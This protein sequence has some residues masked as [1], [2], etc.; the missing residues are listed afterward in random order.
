M[1]DHTFRTPVPLPSERLV[2]E[3]QTHCLFVG[4]CFSDEVGQRASAAGV[5]AVSNPAGALYNMES[6]RL[7]LQRW[8][9]GR[10]TTGNDVFE[11]ADGLWHSRQHS[12]A[13]D[14]RDKA[15]CLMRCRQSDEVGIAAFRKADI[16][17]A[18]AGTNRLYRH[19][20]SS[21]VVANCHKQ[22][23]SEYTEESQSVS[24]M[25]E[26]WCPMLESLPSDKRVVFTVSPYRYAKY[27]M[28]GS[29]LAKA[30][31]LLA[32]DELCRRFPSCVYFPAYEIVLDELRDYRFYAPDMLHV[33]PVAADYVWQRFRSW[34]FSPR[35]EAFANDWE[36][37]R[38]RASHRPRN[39]ESPAQ[40]RFEEETRAAILQ[41]EKKWGRSFPSED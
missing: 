3:P 22:P 27:G 10:L 17:L 29:Q 23:A 28:H 41:L 7:A 16:I 34:T 38:L 15:E 12:S 21:A 9:D 20:E 40:Q 32:I 6:L 18:T 1:T 4:S 11:G 26:A 24:G 14:G 8:Q 33:S 39:P 30:A 13:C 5:C 2:I 19:R 25:V 35:M 31:L 37:I 36:K